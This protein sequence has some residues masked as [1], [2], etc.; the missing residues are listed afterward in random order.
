[1]RIHHSIEILIR[2][3]GFRKIDPRYKGDLNADVRA[4]I[5]KNDIRLENCLFYLFVNC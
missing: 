1:M 3:P 4:T 2:V 5:L